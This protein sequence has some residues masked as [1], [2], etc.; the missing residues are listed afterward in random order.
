MKR[1]SRTLLASGGNEPVSDSGG[2]GH[3]V[4]AQAFM[5]DLR[6]MDQSVFTAEELFYEYV[7]E[8]VAG[9]AEQIPEYN[10]IRNSG[11]KGGDF[12]FKKI[13]DHRK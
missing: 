9:S 2:D 1:S 5:D 13:K 6:D 10:T 8:V 11:H 4:F 3:S 7:K 12:I